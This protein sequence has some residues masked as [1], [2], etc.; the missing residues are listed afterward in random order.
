MFVYT[1]AP[2]YAPTYVHCFVA[3]NVWLCTYALETSIN[4]VI[5]FC[6]GKR[7]WCVIKTKLFALGRWY[8]VD[9]QFV[10]CYANKENDVYLSFIVG[11]FALF[12]FVLSLDALCCIL[13]SNDSWCAQRL[14]PSRMC[15][16][17]IKLWVE[18][19][20]NCCIVVIRGLIDDFVLEL[21]MINIL[22]SWFALF[23]VVE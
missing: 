19:W 3:N 16:L 1:R 11:S 6:H 10:C 22:R 18:T 8:P 20:S 21:S 23:E 13:R 5:M 7:T 15:S 17:S 12:F 14:L 4:V 9:K 2:T